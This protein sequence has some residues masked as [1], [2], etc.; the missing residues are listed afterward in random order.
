[1]TCVAS[2]SAELAR[3]LEDARGQQRAISGRRDP[4]LLARLEFDSEASA[5]GVYAGSEADIR[6]VAEAIRDL[7]ARV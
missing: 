7:A 4:D 2:D 5:V 3:Q 1:M 6:S